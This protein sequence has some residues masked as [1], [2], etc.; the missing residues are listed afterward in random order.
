MNYCAYK[1]S[2]LII[3]SWIFF[4]FFV[5]SQR[6]SDGFSSFHTKVKNYHCWTGIYQWISRISINVSIHD[7]VISPIFRWSNNLSITKV[8]HSIMIFQLFWTCLKI[9]GSFSETNATKL[10]LVC[11]RNCTPQKQQCF[12]AQEGNN[13]SLVVQNNIQSQKMSLDK[14]FSCECYVFWKVSC[15][16]FK[17]AYLT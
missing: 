9:F 12:F 8:A 11:W 10:L 2:K 13:S 6:N 7:E 15:L 1:V 3:F 17:G 14:I 5:E 16:V 4:G